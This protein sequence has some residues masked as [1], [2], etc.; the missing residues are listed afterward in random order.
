M[1][2]T[3]MGRG[4]LHPQGAFSFQPDVGMRAPFYLAGA[5]R[6]PFV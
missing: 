1:L 6:S 4:C 2:T 3:G 5:Q